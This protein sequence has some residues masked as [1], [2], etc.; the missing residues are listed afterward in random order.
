M[1]WYLN[2]NEYV[3]RQADYNFTSLELVPTVYN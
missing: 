1:A 3:S 2:Y